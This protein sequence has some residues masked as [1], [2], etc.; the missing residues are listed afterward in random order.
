MSSFLNNRQLQ[1]MT[2]SRLLKLNYDIM[3]R[4]NGLNPTDSIK[5]YAGMLAIAHFIGPT[6][7]K[8]WREGK[9]IETDVEN[10]LE[11]IYSAGRYGVEILPKLA[12]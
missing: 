10:D 3:I 4:F 5:Q 11:S 12:Q 2:A 1:D 9:K 7:A 6:A 8:M